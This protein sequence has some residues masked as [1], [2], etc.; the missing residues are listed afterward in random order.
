M[1]ENFQI[2]SRTKSTVKMR[3]VFRFPGT[4][5]SEK[6]SASIFW[7]EESMFTV[8]LRM[9]LLLLKSRNNGNDWK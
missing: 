6:F 7:A 9:D 5:N 2:T 4:K 1:K 3:S 8:R